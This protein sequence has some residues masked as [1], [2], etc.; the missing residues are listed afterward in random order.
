MIPSSALPLGLL[1][2]TAFGVVV[3]ILVAGVVE[4]RRLRQER[5]EALEPFIQPVEAL[6]AEANDNADTWIS[7]GDATASV[8]RA[9]AILRGHAPSKSLPEAAE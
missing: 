9:A 5:A 1:I 2:A 4:R 8:V 6:P 3:G 7:L